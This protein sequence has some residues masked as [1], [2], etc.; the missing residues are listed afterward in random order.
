MGYLAENAVFMPLTKTILEESDKFTCGNEDLDDFFQN[1]S[2]AYAEDL[3]ER[4]IAFK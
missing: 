4:H 3:L 2:I 1:D